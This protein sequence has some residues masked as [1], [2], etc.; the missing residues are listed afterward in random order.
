[1]RFA[2]MEIPSPDAPSQ[3]HDAEWLARR[4]AV[5]LRE[6][7]AIAEKWH[8]NLEQMARLL[9]TSPRTLQRWRKLGEETGRLDLAGDTIERMS[10][11]LG[12]SKALTLLLPTPANRLLWLINPNADVLFNG[13]APLQRMLQGQVADLYVVRRHLDAAR[14]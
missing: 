9:G 4:N 12:I 7:L 14:G 6:M 8:L 13:Q 11:L 2:P 1:M 3:P 10:Y 5:G